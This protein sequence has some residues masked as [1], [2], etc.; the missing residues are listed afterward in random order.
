MKIYIIVGTDVCEGDYVPRE[1]KGYKDGY[2]TY[3]RY[4]IFTDPVLAQ[5]TCDKLNIPPGRP[6]D[7]LDRF[8][9]LEQD[10]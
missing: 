7:Q 1:H 8:V 6:M 3:G 10:V 2:P 9:V 4:L 5:D